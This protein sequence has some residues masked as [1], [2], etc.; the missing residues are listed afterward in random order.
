MKLKKYQ[1]YMCSLFFEKFIKVSLIFFCVVILINFFEEVRFSEK[2]NIEVLYIIYL[3]ILN[4]PSLI[5]EI[6]PF[7]F[8]IAIKL[9]YIELNDKSELEIFNSNGIS[10]LKIVYLLTFITSILGI[11]LLI[12]YYSLSSSLKS[13]YL[14]IK[15]RFSNSNEYLAVV[16]DDGLWIKEEIDNKLY[17]IHAEKLNKNKM[18][19]EQVLS[20]SSIE[21]LKNFGLSSQKSFY[22]KNLA[23][24]S[25]NNQLDISSLDKLSSEK[26][27]DLLLPIKGIGQWTINNFK[28]FALQDVNAWPSAD[29]ALQEAVKILQNLI[30]R[31]NQ[32][33][34][35]NLGK[36][37]EPYRGAAAL[38][39]WHFYNKSKIKSSKS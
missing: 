4:A 14:D 2:H 19:S 39:L 11:F 12:F 3:S 22:I 18:L 25:L 7:I 8:F 30:K 27:T 35:E 29:L 15:N 5:F 16:N 36:N 28:I 23:T 37:W 24:L 38:F 20:K 26:V 33:E 10:N 32:I 17:I 1:T 13:H 31:P 21:D 9:F 34:M 6:L